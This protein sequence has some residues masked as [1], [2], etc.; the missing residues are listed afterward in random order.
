MSRRTFWMVGLVVTLLIAGVGSF[1][2]SA[3]PDG[4]EYVAEKTGF[5]DSAEDSPTADGP[6][7]DY[8][9]KGVDDSRV[10]GGIAGVVGVLLVLVLAG[11]LAYAVR[12][13]APDTA[14]PRGSTTDSDED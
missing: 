14:S 4:L 13:R 9:T 3:H 6:F 11:G 7:A 10:G 1:Y 12:R 5:I 2:A 8:S